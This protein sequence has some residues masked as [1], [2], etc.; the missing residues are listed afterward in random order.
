[1]HFHDGHIAFQGNFSQSSQNYQLWSTVVVLL[2]ISGQSGHSWSPI[3][4]ENRKKCPKNCMANGWRQ[5]KILIVGGSQL[6]QVQL[7]EKFCLRQRPPS[8][9]GSPSTLGYLVDSALLLLICHFQRR[10]IF[11]GKR[12]E[13]RPLYPNSKERME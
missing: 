8:A 11:L 13:E 12:C 7:G 10:K 9:L 4:D 2:A 5:I 6:G 1:M 3:N